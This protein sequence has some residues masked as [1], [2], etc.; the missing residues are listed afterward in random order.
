MRLRKRVQVDAQAKAAPTTDKRAKRIE[1]LES[2]IEELMDEVKQL[3]AES[4]TSK[5]E[6]ATSTPRP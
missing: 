3:K 6:E 5:K 1:A 2:L 4:A